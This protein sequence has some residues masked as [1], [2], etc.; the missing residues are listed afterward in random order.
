MGYYA[1]YS[2]S[3]RTRRN[4]VMRKMY[5]TGIYVVGGDLIEFYGKGGIYV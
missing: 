1:R 5:Y 3:R 2:H 4:N